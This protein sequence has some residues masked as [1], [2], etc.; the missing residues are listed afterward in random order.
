[1]R[2]GQK[3][4]REQAIRI[5]LLAHDLKPAEKSGASPNSMMSTSAKMED[6]LETYEKRRHPAELVV[7]LDEKSVTLHVNVC[8]LAP[9]QPGREAAR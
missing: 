8:P 2:V 5:L 4:K 3:L 6:V 9:A 1:M 7:Y